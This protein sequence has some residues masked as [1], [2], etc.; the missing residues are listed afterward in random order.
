[1][2]MKIQQCYCF[3]VQLLGRHNGKVF[4]QKETIFTLGEG[5]DASIPKGIEKALYKFQLNERSL[6]HL[7]DTCEFEEYGIP[8]KS[9]VTYEVKLLSFEKVN[10]NV[11]YLK[12]SF[13]NSIKFF[14]FKF[15]FLFENKLELLVNW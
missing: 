15:Y 6:I 11:S 14:F 1:M 9:S 4:D 10:L 13:C 5:C 12:I 7:K 2:L 3:T 8:N